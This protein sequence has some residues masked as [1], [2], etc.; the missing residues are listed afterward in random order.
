[1]MSKRGKGL[2]PPPIGV[3]PEFKPTPSEVKLAEISDFAKNAVEAERKQARE[4]TARLRKERQKAER[5]QRKL[6][7]TS[8]P[9]ENSGIT[10][11][12]KTR[13]KT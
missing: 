1:M 6:A 9:D 10:L 3:K 4:K 8:R 2:T 12:L 11:R 13:R 7:T 5:G